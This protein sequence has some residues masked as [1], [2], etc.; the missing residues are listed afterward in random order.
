MEAGA[1]GARNKMREFCSLHIESNSEP[2]LPDFLFRKKSNIKVSFTDNESPE[3]IASFKRLAS[4][5]VFKRQALPR[6][7]WSF[8][9]DNI[10]IKAGIYEH[11]FWILNQINP[12]ILLYQI[13]D[14]GFDCKLQYFWKGDGEGHG[15][16]VTEKVS[17][18]LVLHRIDIQFGFYYCNNTTTNFR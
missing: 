18:L 17:D 1:E 13:N 10:D 4:H 15:P 8:D 3:R 6:Y 9:S 11:V 12:G 16:I 14:L 2:A 5:G 7:R